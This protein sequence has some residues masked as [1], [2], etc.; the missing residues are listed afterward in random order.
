MR[1]YPAYPCKD[2]NVEFPTAKA[3]SDHLHDPGRNA[4]VVK[5]AGKRKRK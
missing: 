4:V 5:C 2:C 1:E 3:F